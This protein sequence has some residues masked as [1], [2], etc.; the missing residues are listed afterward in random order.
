M[1]GTQKI[2]DSSEYNNELI[3][4]ESKFLYNVIIGGYCVVLDCIN[5]AL[6]RVIERLNGLIDKKIMIKKKY[7]KYL[8]IVK[9]PLIKINKDFTFI[10][11]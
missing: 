10:K 4:F 11:L 3:K 6:S 5:E 1:N 9:K 2:S 8:K 7:L